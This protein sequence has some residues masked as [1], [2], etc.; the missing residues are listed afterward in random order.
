MGITLL[1][2]LLL[3]GLPA[4]FFLFSCA[5]GRASPYTI[6]L[7]SVEVDGLHRG[8]EI[9]PLKDAKHFIAIS[10]EDFGHILSGCPID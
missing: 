9:V 8:V 1:L 4:S 10:P 3:I 2:K 6:R 7:Y 5:V